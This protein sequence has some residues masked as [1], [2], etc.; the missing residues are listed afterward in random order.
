MTARPARAAA[1]PAPADAADFAKRSA[2]REYAFSERE[3][4]RIVAILR[5]EAGIDMPRAKEPLVYSRLA[6]RIR[7]LG[8]D[9]FKD[10][11]ALLEHPG[12]HEIEHM[13]VA[14]TT[15]VTRF[16]R[17]PHHFDDLRTRVMPGLIEKARARQR[18]RIWSAGCSSGQEPYSIALTVLD[19]LPDARS[20]DLRILA[21]DINTAVLAEAAQ[22]DYAA[23]AVQPAPQALRARHFRDA[24]GGRLQ[25]SDELRGLIAF[26]QLNLMGDWPMKHAF[27]VIFCRNVAIYFDEE[28]QQGLWRRFAERLVAGGRFYIGHSERVAGPASAMLRTDGVTTYVRTGG[29]A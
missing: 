10:Y 5:A 15:N 22:G 7:Q 24:G 8:L 12:Q 20:H 1:A 29:A 27:D 21:T 19:C 28:T 14:L 17:E 25:A 18:V 9:T 23:E 3:F 2:P 26:R 6:K 4:D 11:I 16:F 13:L